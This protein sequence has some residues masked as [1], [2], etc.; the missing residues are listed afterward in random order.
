MTTRIRIDFAA[1]SHGIS[2]HV[3]GGP[4]HWIRSAMARARQRRAVGEL[5]DRLLKDI[6]ITRAQAL[7]EAGKP[8]WRP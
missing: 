2:V 8:F 5:D 7:G 4:L 6:G 1:P 3:H